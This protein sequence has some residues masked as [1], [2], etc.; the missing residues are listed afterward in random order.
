MKNSNASNEIFPQYNYQSILK[1][2][3]YK[4]IAWVIALIWP[5]I[6][7]VG[8]T[9]LEINRHLVCLRIN[10]VHYTEWI[11]CILLVW[12]VVC[13]FL[14][15]NLAWTYCFILHIYVFLCHIHSFSLWLN[16]YK[17]HSSG[18]LIS[19]NFCVLD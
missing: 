9:L 18:H 12:D 16:W 2:I 14:L 1:S 7:C 5:L 17:S 6:P 4:C 19:W 15:A 10:L 8:L 11:K 13:D 3:L